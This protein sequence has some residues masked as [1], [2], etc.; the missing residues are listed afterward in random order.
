MKKVEQEGDQK[1]NCKAQIFFSHRTWEATIL[2]Q[3]PDSH[4]V[5]RSNLWRA[6]G[7]RTRLEFKHFR[8]NAMTNA[9]LHED[10]IEGWR[11]EIRDR[12]VVRTH[13]EALRDDRERTAEPD[14]E[15]AG[16]APRPATTTRITRTMRPEYDEHDEYD[17]DEEIADGEDGDDQD[18]GTRT[19]A[20][21][22]P[23]RSLP[24][25]VCELGK[26]ARRN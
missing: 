24:L 6:P 18:V 4:I 5:W 8:R 7:R 11:G 20:L 14:E 21:L 23:L 25:R 9:I 22:P 17:R 10:E 19:R 1:V 12:E 15:P 16:E 2:E 3:V 26:S 13:E